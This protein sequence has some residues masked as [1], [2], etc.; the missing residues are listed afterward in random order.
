[1]W[2]GVH[3]WERIANNGTQMDV[4]LPNSC[5]PILYRL[6]WQTAYMVSHASRTVL[7]E[8]IFFFFFFFFLK[9]RTKKQQRKSIAVCAGYLLS[10]WEK[11]T[12][13]ASRFISLTQEGGNYDYNAELVFFLS[14]K[15]VLNVLAVSSQEGCTNRPDMLYSKVLQTSLN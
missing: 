2:S 15:S 9:S 3:F 13:A 8:S 11:G 5:P 12:L 14:A 7:L 10:L 1:M 6:S 4:F